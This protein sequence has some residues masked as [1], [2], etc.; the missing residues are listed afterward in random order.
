MLLRDELPG[1]LIPMELFE[2]SMA[3]NRP[4]ER[5]PAWPVVGSEVYYRRNSWDSDDALWRMRVIDAQ[6]PNDTTTVWASNLCQQ[7]RDNLTG[8]PLLDG[9]GAPVH[10]PLTDPWPWVH[11][12]WEGALPSGAP[13]W[14]GNVQMTWESRLR[15]SPGWLPLDYQRTRTVWLPGDLTPAQSINQAAG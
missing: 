14:L 9:N 2:G 1:R 13:A 8:R 7:I 3:R 10:S 15:G 12:R 11:L 5:R 4:T 6:D